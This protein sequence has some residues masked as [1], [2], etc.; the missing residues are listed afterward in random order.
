MPVA[1]KN[2]SFETVDRADALLIVGSSLQV[3]SAMRLLNRARERGAPI[4]VVNL[5]PTRGDDLCDV[6]LDTPC[7]QVLTAVASDL[8]C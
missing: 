8:G 6:R 5:G 3:F 4:A 1:V 7:T 2:E